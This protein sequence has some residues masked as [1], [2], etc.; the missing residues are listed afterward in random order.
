MSGWEVGSSNCNSNNTSNCS[1]NCHSNYVSNG[2]SKCTSKHKL[3]ARHTAPHGQFWETF[4]RVASLGTPYP[5]VLHFT[6]PLSLL[7]ARPEP[8]GVGGPLK[9]VTR[10]EFAS[11]YDQGRGAWSVPPCCSHSK[12]AADTP[13]L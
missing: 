1:S 9:L 2:N 8:G 11:V 12:S 5:G 3:V 10:G 13:P 4:I 7:P 6:P